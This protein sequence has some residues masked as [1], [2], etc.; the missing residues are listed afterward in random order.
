M[1]SRHQNSQTNLGLRDHIKTHNEL[2]TLC[3]TFHKTTLFNDFV[4]LVK[5]VIYVSSTKRN[6]KLLIK[7]LA[8]AILSFTPQYLRTESYGSPTKNFELVVLNL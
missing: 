4:E 7:W 5:K 2:K 6:L 1:K 3:F 8:Y